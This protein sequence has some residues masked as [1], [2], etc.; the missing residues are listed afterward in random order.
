[1]RNLLCSNSVLRSPD[2]D[3]PFILHTDALDRGVGAI[4]SQ[5]DGGGEEHPVG[6]FSRKLLPSEEKHATVE[7]CLTIR[8]GVHEFR[9]YPLGKPFTIQTDHRC[10]EWLARMKDTNSRL[11]RWSLAYKIQISYRSSKAN[12]NAEALS[13]AFVCMMAQQTSL[14][15]DRGGW[16][17]ADCDCSTLLNSSV[18]VLFAYCIVGLV[19]F[20]WLCQF[21]MFC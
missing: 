8:L 10:L 17:V 3:H 18:I 4:L 11:T 1:M 7:E 9:V 5:I 2:F 16:S 13:Q 15:Q 19:D 21:F 20:V 12:G 6:Y 14:S